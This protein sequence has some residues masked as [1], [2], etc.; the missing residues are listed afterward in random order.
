ML[1]PVQTSDI[2]TRELDEIHSETC[3]EEP[4]HIDGMSKLSEVLPIPQHCLVD[5]GTPSDVLARLGLKSAAKAQLR[6]AQRL[7]KLKPEP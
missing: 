4:Q 7:S 3:R 1:G 6:A 2:E 5:L